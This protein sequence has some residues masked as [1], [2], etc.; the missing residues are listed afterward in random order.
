MDAEPSYRCWVGDGTSRRDVED[1]RLEQADHAFATAWMVAVG[2]VASQTFAILQLRQAY[3]QVKLYNAV[4][5]A[6][7]HCHQAT[8]RGSPENPTGTEGARVRAI[9]EQLQALCA[10]LQQSRRVARAY[11]LE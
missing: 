7:S 10:F 11:V 5:E 8:P 2:T 6:P 4:V 9:Q 3:F 1:R